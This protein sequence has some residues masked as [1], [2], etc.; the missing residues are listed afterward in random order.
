MS[1]IKKLT[2]K[3]KNM[4]PV[5]KTSIALIIARFFQK[6]LAMITGPIFTRIM[7]SS[8]YGIIATFTTWQSILLI[9][10]TLNMSS[11]VFNNGMLEF[12]KDRNRFTFSIL[13]LANSIT[14][15][16]GIVYVVFYQ[17][18]S[19]IINLPIPLMIIMGLYFLTFPAYSYW[20]GRARFEFRYKPVL[21]LTI[22]VSLASTLGA[23]ALVLLADEGEK[24]TA[25]IVG[26]E[27]VMILVGIIFYI[28]TFIK[29]RGKVK[30]EYWKYA[31][32]IN[33]P[34]VPHYLS[35]HVLSGSDK[36]MIAN[37]VSTSATAIYN[38]SY[39]VAAILLIFWDAV[40]SAFAPWI[41]QKMEKKDYAPL[42]KRAQSMM[43]VFALFA[44]LITLFAPEIIR[45]L[46][47]EEYYEGI[48]IIPSV[49][50]GVFFTAVF[51]LYMRVELYLKKST[52]IMIGTVAA[53]S[54][55]LL[56]NWIFIPIFGYWA[57]GYT[58]MV[59][60]MMLALFHAINLKRLGYGMVYNNKII[61]LMA[62]A[63]CAVII[64]CILTYQFTVIRYILIAILFV[65][66]LI[67]RKE[68]ISLVKGNKKEKA[69]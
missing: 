24:S 47:P 36:I 5:A 67:K 15:I 34:L 48:Y 50:S 27:S 69:T 2:S 23:L 12:K 38:V 43:V 41:Y 65:I 42:Q 17:W 46:G 63:L 51:T 8:E 22:V 57:A 44:L 45:I 40:D 6:G 31:L 33:L 4:S 10:A 39:T 64:A 26:T 19:P 16:W 55:N 14:L 13:L 56:L 9:I 66:A 62:I 29:A 68:I 11:G 54:M 3:Y 60:Y 21:V 52:T 37:M 25:K 49:V 35:M 53:A 59:C 18:L 20:M 61:A 1:K 58:T 30:F 28:I 7:P 32:A